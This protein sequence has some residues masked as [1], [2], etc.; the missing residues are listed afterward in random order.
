MIKRNKVTIYDIAEQAGVS[1]GTVSRVLKGSAN[2]KP[3]TRA[4]IEEVIARCNYQP[5]AVARGLT[6]SHTHTLGIILPKLTNPNYV[7]IFEGAYDEAAANG[8]VMMLFPWENM[9]AAGQDIVVVLGERRLDGVIICLEFI[10][11]EMEK[12]RRKL[13]AIQQ[14]MPVVLT[15]SMPQALEYPSVTN[16]LAER[17]AQTIQMLAERGHERIALLGGFDESDA[18][19]SRDA[20]YARG[21]Q[22]AHLPYIREYR[23]FGLCTIDDGARQFETMLSQLLPSQWPTAVIAANDL[24]GVGVMRAAQARGLRVPEDVS[25]IGCDNIFICDCV[26]PPL[27]SVCTHQSETGR[28]AVRMLLGLEESGRR[29]MPCEM[30]E[31]GSCCERKKA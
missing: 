10:A 12:W 23:Q 3:A 25:V 1:I 17:T 28:L 13:D 27:T 29:M 24:V 8:Y 31:R 11:N 9:N 5:S 16:D 18:P 2:V 15:G 7:K 14:Y 22:A 26:Q 6:Q 20:G 21:L 19:Y 4:K 30:I